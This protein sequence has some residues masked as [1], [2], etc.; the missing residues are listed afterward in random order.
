MSQIRSPDVNFP[1]G[2]GG[3]THRG[4]RK[5]GKR[6]C[7]KIVLSPNVLLNQSSGERTSLF[8][9]STLSTWCLHEFPDIVDC[10]S[11]RRRW[12]R[13]R[14]WGSRT[15]H[16]AAWVVYWTLAA[17]QPS[18]APLLPDPLPLLPTAVQGSFGIFACNTPLSVPFSWFSSGHALHPPGTD[19]RPSYS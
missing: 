11:E 15:L 10:N 12:S 6:K 7:C 17:G 2:T 1:I 9:Q 8:K 14:S 3:L 13:S 16:R 18:R 19:S 4:G 5:S